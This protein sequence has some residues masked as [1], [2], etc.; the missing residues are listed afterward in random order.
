MKPELD[1]WIE[2]VSE[3]LEPVRWPGAVL[4]RL[5]AFALVGGG[6]V[7]ALVS[8]TGSLRVGA[9]QALL[10]EP[11]FL[12][13]C[14]VGLAV[15]VAAGFFALRAGI[16]GDRTARTG[17]VL[18]IG[19]IALWAGLVVSS[20]VWP[21]FEPSM[22]GK[23]PGCEWQTLLF[24][25]PGLALGLFLVRGLAP[26]D[27]AIAGGLIGAGAMALPALAM[28]LACMYDPHHALTHH[29]LPGLGVVALGVALGP[30]VL[31]RI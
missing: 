2:Q 23:R 9:L 28:Q 17:L 21:I 25:L 18:V 22:A 12:L 4:P 27:R 16:P 26:F 11:R 3:D 20:G 1:A 13:E 5:L 24:A 30:I 19:G 31:R 6:F 7:A 10:E 8:S 15:S 29:G 14:G